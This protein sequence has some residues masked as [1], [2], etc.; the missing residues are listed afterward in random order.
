MSKIHI[1]IT[2]YPGVG[3]TTLVKNAVAILQKEGYCV[4]GFYTEE[5]RQHGTRIGFD[6]VD[7]NGTRS[8][9]ARLTASNSTGPRVGKYSV[10]VKSFEDVSLPTLNPPTLP[11]TVIVIDEIGK[12]E[13]FSKAFQDAVHKIF[14]SLNCVIIATVPVSKGKPFPIVDELLS[15]KD[16]VLFTVTRECRDHMINEV[17][18][19]IKISISGCT[20]T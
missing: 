5:I 10:D 4:K 2:G 18:S 13:L 8:S 16:T 1:L 7:L 6:V 17:V 20:D 15:R 14:N 9:L 3:K 11:K 19:K 12:M